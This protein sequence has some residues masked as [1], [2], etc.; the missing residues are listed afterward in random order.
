MAVFS[1]MNAL[2]QAATSAMKA[3]SDLL[4]IVTGG[5]Y[6]RAPA[7]TQYPMISME[8]S[9]A[10]DGSYECNDDSVEI[11]LQIAVWD[12]SPESGS[13]S[14]NT[15]NASE[16][17]FLVKRAIMTLD[18]AQLTPDWRVVSVQYRTTRNITASDGVTTQ[19]VNTFI[20]IVE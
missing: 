17:S 3:D 14:Y 18:G 15:F 7:N 16:A 2:K 13:K 19:S 5:I 10:V 12:Y 1:P 11:T 8:S 6:D 20:V 4:G 9:F